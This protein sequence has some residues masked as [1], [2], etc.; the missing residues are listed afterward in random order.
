MNGEIMINKDAILKAI[1]EPMQQYYQDMTGVLGN[2]QPLERAA[3]LLLEGGDVRDD[4]IPPVYLPLLQ[5]MR[6][7]AKVT[8]ESEWDWADPRIQGIF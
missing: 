6:L 4:E 2:W 1:R 8:R 3:G 7:I 5:M